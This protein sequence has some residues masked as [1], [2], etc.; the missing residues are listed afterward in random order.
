[1]EIINEREREL[2]EELQ[3]ILEN[4]DE[5]ELLKI[6]NEIYKDYEENIISPMYELAENV[7][8][9]EIEDLIALGYDG[10]NPYDNY[11]KK[12]FDDGLYTFKNLDEAIN[13]GELME[14]LIADNEDFGHE[15]IRRILDEL[16]EIGE[17]Y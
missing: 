5:E 14:D 16:N 15:D 2:K 9:W 6:N 11:F 3:K 13:L 7:K 8:D 17:T 1:M 12:W 10:F 4:L